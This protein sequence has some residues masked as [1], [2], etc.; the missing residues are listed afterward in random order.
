MKEDSRYF[1]KN[2]KNKYEEIS[3]QKLKR[4]ISYYNKKHFIYVQNMY[5]EVN[6]KE[7]TEYYKEFE[8][9]KYTKNVTKKLT[10]FSVDE[11]KYNEDSSYKDIIKDPNCNVE[12]KAILNI[13]IKELRLAL[14]KLTKEEYNLIYELFFK[15]TT[16]TQYAKNHK[17]PIS[18][19][20]D[21]K[22]RILKKLKNFIKF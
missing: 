4:Y 16:L 2:K 18:T 10:A 7:Y 1:I 13:M 21:A 17:L 12:D 9:N 22:V 20:Y 19:T 3:Y 6:E 8:R 15:D 11:L 5:L 14:Y